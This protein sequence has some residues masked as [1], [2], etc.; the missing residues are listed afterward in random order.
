MDKKDLII[1]AFKNYDFNT[2]K[3]W[4]QSINECGFT[5]DKVIISINSSD[6]TNKQLVDAGFIVIATTSKTQMMF[7]MERFIHIY[8]FLENNAENYRYVIS[9]DVR[10]VIF[11]T[12][13]SVYLERAL[14]D[15]HIVAVSESI[16]IKNEPWNLDN[17]TKS[18]GP[19][20]CESV[21]DQDVYNVGTLAGDSEYIRDLCGMLFQLSYN[22]ADWVADQAA[23]NI[24]LNWKPYTDIVVWSTLNDAFACNLHVTHKP[25]QLEL[26]GPHLLEPRP[27]FEDGVVKDGK[28][29]TP[30]CIVHQYDRNP[31]MLSYFNTK[32]GVEDLITIR[33]I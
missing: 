22:R 24:L 15:K 11:Q 1:G 20:F 9:T 19:Y 12:N 4:V 17:I 10:D 32:Y 21:L 6:E 3:P 33:T 18:F 29:K 26:F 7:H 8:D 16:K 28:N 25:D 2:L 13:P 5:G 27:V 30:F 14:G 31:E 23:Y